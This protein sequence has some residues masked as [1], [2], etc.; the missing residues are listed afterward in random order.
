MKAA[1]RQ[2]A[3]LAAAT[4]CF[5]GRGYHATGVSDI[6]EGAGVARGTFYLYFDS[7]HDVFCRILDDF[8]SHLGDQ[9]KT[10][11][12]GGAL[13]PAQQMRM[14][15]ER[16]VD[17]VLKRPGPAKIVFREA[18][19]QGAEVDRKLR[20]FY[21]RLISIIESS[22]CKG[23][24]LGLVRE[25]DPRAAACIII[26]GF[27]ELMVQKIV[28]KNASLARDA[29]VDGLIDVVLGGLGGRPVVN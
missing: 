25:V 16:L 23:M 15:V 14:N 6:I 12:L 28:F 9:I 5:A 27:R 1:E 22:L 24:S 21:G 17:A 3:L 29:I 26:G 13:T 2:K 11:E 20:A 8:I 4:R 10:V 19:G 7:K 18:A